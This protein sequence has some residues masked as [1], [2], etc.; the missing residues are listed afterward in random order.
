MHTFSSEAGSI[1]A[2]SS[3]RAWVR[4]VLAALL[5]LAWLAVAGIGG[6]YFGKISEVSTN[7]QTDFLPASAES[8]QVV[9][10]QGDF[11]GTDAVPAILVFEADGSLTDSHQTYLEGL[12]DQLAASGTFAG[13]S[14][15]VIY[16]EDGRA[17]ELILPIST[18]QET[19]EVVDGIRAEIAQAPDGLT[20]YVTGPAGF[21]ADLVEAF[22]GIDGIL[23]AVALIVVFVILLV[24][25]RSP[26][27]PIIVL[28]SSMVALSGAIF[29]IW[30]MANAGWVMINGQ[31]QGILLI[32]VVGAA[33]DYSLLYVARYRE[34]LTQYT[35]RWE[36]TRAAW[37]GSLEP[38][39]A[40]GGTVIAGLLCLLLSELSSNKALGPVAATGIVLSMLASLT[41]LP[42]VLALL[43]RVA[44]WPAR[45]RYSS[46]VKDASAGFWAKIAAFVSG[47]P[48]MVWLVTALVLA[49]F[50]G[51]SATFQANGVR[52]SDLVLGESQARDGQNVLVEHFPGGSGSPANV[53]IP[54]S[55]Q[56]DAVAALDALDGVSSIAAVAQDSPAGTVPVGASTQSAPPIF[57]GISPTEVEGRVMLQVTL[58]DP[59]DSP[60]AEE[61]VRQMRES[62]ASAAPGSLV[63]G[64]TASDLDTIDSAQR[65][66][67]L[68]IPVVLVVITLILMVLLRSILAPLILVAA[69]VLSYL[70]ALGVSALVFNHVFNFPGADPTVP[71]YGFVFLVALGIDYTIFLMT[72]V[73]EEALHQGAESGLRTALVATGG[74][75]TSAGIVLAATFAALGVIPLIFLAQ[76]AFIVAF[77]V[78]LDATVVR[79]LLIPAL[80]EDLGKKIWWPSRLSR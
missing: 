45:P 28:M 44:F 7:S 64:T 15:P 63:G 80:V 49:I 24:V 53:I 16:S 25:Y 47:R 6:P 30:H 41:F 27:L 3:S 50:A 18:D 20:G 12:T 19:R 70:T 71:L 75:I 52:Q 40:S 60:E 78:L 58:A 74:V 77:G 2:G 76:L 51:F 26:L 35:S 10:Q 32:L 11:L 8:T 68:I 48:R 33:T 54:A 5:T 21:S 37:R 69:T 14:S 55:E 46:E 22:G 65:D 43:G 1:R 79:A 39:L 17:A 23:L 42:A 67:A 73:R 56:D 38:I 62:L 31:V 72:R 4:V 61:T 59:A 36:A 29:V 9:E 13:E 34:A 57:A 66:R